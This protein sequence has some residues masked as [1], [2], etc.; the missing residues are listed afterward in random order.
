M[1]KQADKV[2]WFEM[3][4]DDV[5]RASE[6]YSKVFDWA[7]P[8]M[9][10]DAAFALTVKADKNGNPTEVGG[11][12]GGFHKRQGASDAG[13]VINIHVDDIDAKLKAIE[14]NGGHVIQP[15]TEVGEYGLSMALFSDT[16]GNIMGVYNYSTTK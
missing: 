2:S 10:D 12:N 1:T 16:E 7:T 13:P 6:F 4:V 9:G 15:R 3:P 14:T 5:T 11:I 8:P